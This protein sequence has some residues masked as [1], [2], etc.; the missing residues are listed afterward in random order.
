MGD[1]EPD[2]IVGMKLPDDWEEPSERFKRQRADWRTRMFEGT[3][4]QL[5]KQYSA[6]QIKSEDAAFQL[7][8]AGRNRRIEAARGANPDLRIEAPK[9]GRGKYRRR[10]GR[11]KKVEKGVVAWALKA[12][13]EIWKC[14]FGQQNRKSGDNLAAEIVAVWMSRLC[15]R[16]FSADE[17]LSLRKKSGR[18]KPGPRKK[19]S[20]QRRFYAP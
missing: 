20:A 14:H 13:R 4:D 1:D 17:I 12:V 9:R 18:P 3:C 19:R 16:T 5:D 11:H 8:E 15:D 2:G 10:F 6:R 7:A